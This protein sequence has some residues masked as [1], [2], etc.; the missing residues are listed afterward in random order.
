MQNVHIV[1][2]YKF[3]E[4][5]DPEGFAEAQREF[6]RKE[7]LRG[8]LLVAREG[9]N[10]SFAGTPERMERYKNFLTS[11]NG[12]S[13]VNFKEETASFLPFRKLIVRVKNEIIRLEKEV[14]MRRRGKYITPE[15]LIALYESGEDFIIL[16]TRNAYE[17]EVGRFRN[18]VTPDIDSFREFPEALEKLS[19]RKDSKIVTYCTGGI[20]CE[21]ATAYM[22]S[23]GFTDVYQ[24][25]DGI[26]NFCQKYPDTVWEGKCFVFDDRLVSDVEAEGDVIS[27]CIICGESCDRYQNCRNTACDD[28]VILCPGCSEENE[29]CCSPECLEEY[30]AYNRTKTRERQGYRSRTARMIQDS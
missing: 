17:S 24:L 16:D 23:R 19:D 22:I 26:I 30:Q 11:I 7:G 25:K 3:T 8:K 27:R 4:I 1:L 21:K 12:F 14:D 20:R 15:E 2:F 18:A 29:G 10:G 13:D 6:C 9:I 28:L 5:A